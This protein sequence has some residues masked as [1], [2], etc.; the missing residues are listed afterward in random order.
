MKALDVR[1]FLAPWTPRVLLPSLDAKLG[2][3]QNCCNA[4]L[5]GQRRRS[6]AQETFWPSC[7]SQAFCANRTGTSCVQLVTAYTH[8][9]CLWHHKGDML[10]EA[11]RRFSIAHSAF[12]RHRRLLYQNRHLD[13]RRRAELFRTLILSKFVYGCESWTLRD[14]RTRHFVHSSL[15]RLNKRLIPGDKAFTLSDDEALSVTGLP[16]PADLFRMQRLRHLGALYDSLCLS[17]CCRLGSP[18]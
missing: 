5:S 15:M 14:A 11:R 3:G 12:Q 9:G 10:Q 16:N 18:Q 1:P 4:D 7:T 2:S 8:A 6:C 13:L 17:F